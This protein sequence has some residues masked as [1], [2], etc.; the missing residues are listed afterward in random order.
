MKLLKDII[1]IILLVILCKTLA[2]YYDAKEKGEPHNIL[3]EGAKTTRHTINNIAEG[4]KEAGEE[5]DSLA[6]DT[7]LTP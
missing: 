5:I 7:T 2:G 1:S 3:K 4:W 6:T